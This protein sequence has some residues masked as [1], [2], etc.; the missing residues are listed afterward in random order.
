MSRAGLLAACGLWV[1][2]IGA[3]VG[4]VP[5][6]KVAL[7]QILAL[8]GDREGNFVR[9]EAALGRARDAG[10]K[11]ACFPETSVL[12]WVNPDAHQRAGPIPGPDTERLST[13]ARAYGLYLCA[14]LAEKE[15]DRL[16]DS[17]VLI[18]PHGEILLKHRKINILT[19]LMDPPYTPG[20]DVAV[21]DTPF[22][23]VGLLICAD[24]FDDGVCRRLADLRPDLVLIPY[25]WAARETD[26]P[27]H[28]KSL[29]AI[30]QQTAR[31]TRAPVIGT[32]LVGAITHGPWTGMVYGGQSVAADAHGTTLV[33][34]ADRQPDVRIVSISLSTGDAL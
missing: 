25:G 6:V 2:G 15:G 1:W 21:A 24:S 12:G 8:D 33:V 18:D 16:Y 17:A 10:A 28:G 9:L 26:W 5:T 34:A 19:E 7:C 20:E 31:R 3:A 13:L 27:D 22:G 23:R 32:D 30:V 11:I 4:E 29:E 14:G